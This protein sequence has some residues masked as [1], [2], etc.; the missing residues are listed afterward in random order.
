MQFSMLD[1]WERAEVER[2]IAQ[3]S[4][5][6]STNLVLQATEVARYLNP[7]SKTCFPLEYSYYLLGDARGMTVLDY[8]CG[9]GVNTLLL[10]RRGAKVKAL[11]ISP[12]LIMVARQRLAANNITADVDFVVGSAHRLPLLDD[13]VDVV[14]GMAILH[15]LDLTLSASEVKRVLREGGRAIF[16]EPVRNSKLVGTLR[17]IIPYKPYTVSQFERPLTDKELGSYANGFSSFRSKAFMLPITNLVG[18]VPWLRRRF[19]Q[20]CYRWEAPILQKFPALGYYA[21]MRVI[22]LRK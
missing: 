9:D 4:R 8:G 20:T 22:E 3:A 16:R 5:I 18:A 11:D 17:S 14:F 7:S 6:K 21:S 13:S 1:E 15:H 19:I 2:S 12:D 10:T